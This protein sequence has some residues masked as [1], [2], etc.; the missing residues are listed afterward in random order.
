[1]ASAI[2]GQSPKILLC[3]L[4]SFTGMWSSTLFHQPLFAQTPPLIPPAVE[5]EVLVAE[6]LVK[7][8]GDVALPLELEKQIYDTITTK[9]G[10]LTTRS[11]I[12]ED[13]K[14]VFALGFVSS[15]QPRP[16]DTD[17]GVRILFVVQP[18]PHIKIRRHGRY[19]CCPRA[20]GNRSIVC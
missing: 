13:A 18:N 9:P 8:E 11:R 2:S 16:E 1:M 19:F 14:R 5:P 6:V 17:V 10:R 20:W 12:E 15:V 7:V 3:S 4:L